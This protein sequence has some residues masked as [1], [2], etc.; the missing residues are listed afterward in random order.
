MHAEA[1]EWIRRHA[2]GCANLGDT[3]GGP[4]RVLDLGGRNVNGSAMD[5]FPD[6]WV[7]VLDIADGP[8]VH[9]VADASTWVPDD[10]WDVVVSAECFEHTD[11]WPAICG[12]AFKALRP[13]GEFIVTCAGPGRHPH[14][15]VDGGRRLFPGE[16]YA[17][18]ST[19]ELADVLTDC[20][21][22]DVITDSLGEDTR[23]WARKPG[24]TG[25]PTGNRGSGTGESSRW[26][27]ATR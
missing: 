14:S 13:L 27:Q 11:S 23:A 5:H 20:G 4:T 26:N 24:S 10:E 25:S 2:V 21:F 8:G 9:I 12:T 19:D 1:Y 17:N 6:A 3:K 22:V 16:H 15:A 7:T 18:V